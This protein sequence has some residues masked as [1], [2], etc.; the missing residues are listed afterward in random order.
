MF[1]SVIRSKRTTRTLIVYAAFTLFSLAVSEIYA[2]F[3]HGVSSVFMTW[4][5][6][7]PLIFGVAAFALGALLHFPPM[8]RAAFNLYNS[9]VA[10]A[11]TASLLRG[12]LEI[13]GTSSPLL[14]VFPLTAGIFAAAALVLWILAVPR[15]KAQA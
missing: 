5:F 6:C 2:R 10:A 12:V 7:I 9:A 13:A 11:A 14:I 3:S 15:G 1:T 4:L 8:P